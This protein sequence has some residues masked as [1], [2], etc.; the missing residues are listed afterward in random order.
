MKVIKVNGKS[1]PGAQVQLRNTSIGGFLR[2]D[3]DDFTALSAAPDAAH[4]DGR[5]A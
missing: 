5:A 3:M 4:R 1:Q 2:R